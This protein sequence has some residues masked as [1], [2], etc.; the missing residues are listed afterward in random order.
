MYIR[1]CVIEMLCNIKQMA[2]PTTRY[3]ACIRMLFAHSGIMGR[4]SSFCTYC[5]QYMVTALNTVIWHMLLQLCVS[6]SNQ[7]EMHHKF[8]RNICLHDVGDNLAP[9][10]CVQ[11]QAAMLQF[12]CQ[13]NKL[14]G[15]AVISF[16]SQRHQQ[17]LCIQ[18]CT[19][20]LD[21]DCIYPYSSHIYVAKT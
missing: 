1:H 17:T 14:Q 2:Q 18:L 5:K 20:I 4:P 6:E 3:R 21:F 7:T 15:V 12:T 13:F 16:D 8:G 10:M 19:I 9:L 11:M